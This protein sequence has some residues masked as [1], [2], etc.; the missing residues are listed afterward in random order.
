MRIGV[1]T[2]TV[3]VAVAHR[4]TVSSCRYF[5]FQI[6]SLIGTYITSIES[7][8]MHHSHSTFHPYLSSL[9]AH[10][11]ATAIAP[12]ALLLSLQLSRS[13][14]HPQLSIAALIYTFVSKHMCMRMRHMYTCN[15]Y[16]CLF[17]VSVIVRSICN[18]FARTNDDSGVLPI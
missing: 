9:I 18:L 5:T 2:A 11:S 4:S 14:T 3:V 17:T 8:C 15:F 12:P 7:C 1:V 16:S 13:R 6:H 10:D